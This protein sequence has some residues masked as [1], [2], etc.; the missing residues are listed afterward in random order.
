MTSTLGHQGST[1]TWTGETGL[2]L[3]NCCEERCERILCVGT[4]L[5]HLLKIQRQ[6]D[7]DLDFV[8][9]AGPDEGFAALAAE[10]AFDV[11]IS[12]LRLP[13]MQ[14]DI[15]YTRL[16]QHSPDAERLILVPRINAKIR[17]AIATD[18]RVM[19]LLIEPCSTSAIREA[20]SDALL[21]HRARRLRAAVVP[22]PTPPGG[23]PCAG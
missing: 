18:A 9:A 23:N 22:R 5:D 6:L 3:V 7:S 1:S 15:F 14:G 2:I 12:C 19:R 11:I 13:G 21:R 10:T 20:V 8:I 4:R 16:R 17:A